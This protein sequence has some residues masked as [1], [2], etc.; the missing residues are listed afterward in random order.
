MKK[1]THYERLFD[2]FWYFPSAFIMSYTTIS[3]I[4]HSEWHKPIPFCFVIG[5][6][7]VL[8]MSKRDELKAEQGDEIK[9]LKENLGE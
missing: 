2:F 8:C 9:W 6:L 5:F 1:Y 4:C 7:Y 3:I